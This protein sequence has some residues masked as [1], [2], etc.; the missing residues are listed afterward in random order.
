MEC[1]QSDLSEFRAGF[2]S[3][4]FPASAIWKQKSPK[5][6]RNDETTGEEARLDPDIQKYSYWTII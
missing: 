3:R 1:Q 2:L 6:L 4:P 5:V